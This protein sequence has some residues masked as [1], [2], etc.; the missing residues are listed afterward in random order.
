MVLSRLVGGGRGIRT[1]G[2]VSGTVVFK[3]TAIDHSAIPPAFASVHHHACFGVA[4]QSAEGATAAASNIRPE[5]VAAGDVSERTRRELEQFFIATVAFEARDLAILG[6]V[7][8]REDRLR[9]SFPSITLG[10]FSLI[11]PLIVGGLPGPVDCVSGALMQVT[12][13]RVRIRAFGSVRSGQQFTCERV[14]VR[15]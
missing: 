11:A 15:E 10:P 2:T 4:R 3:T 5:F 8:V 9:L 1:P 12:S 7:N 14:N 13:T 6:W